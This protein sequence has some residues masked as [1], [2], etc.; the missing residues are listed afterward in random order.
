MIC[1][2]CDKNHN[3]VNINNFV[4]VQCHALHIANNIK[5]TSTRPLQCTDR[6]ARGPDQAE[7]LVK[8]YCVQS[9]A[10]PL[11]SMAAYYQPA[12]VCSIGS[13]NVKQSKCTFVR[14]NLQWRNSKISPERDIRC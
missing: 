8:Q 6:P 2:L 14:W 7:N 11:P 9:S 1:P 13:W 4:S 3:I 10:G 12:L 5:V